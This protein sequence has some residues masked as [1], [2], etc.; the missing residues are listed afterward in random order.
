MCVCV[1]LYIKLLLAQIN[2]N[3]KMK[4]LLWDGKHILRLLATLIYS[5]A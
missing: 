2:L 5:R 4:D 1:F 3:K